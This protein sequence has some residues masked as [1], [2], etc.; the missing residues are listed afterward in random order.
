MVEKLFYRY[1]TIDAEDGLYIHLSIFKAVRETKCFYIVRGYGVN[2]SGFE[3]IHGRERR[4]L[5]SDE[6]CRSI[7]HTKESAMREFKRRQV[8]R[9]R[10]ANR[11]QQIAELS[12]EFL[13]ANNLSSLKDE[14]QLITEG[15]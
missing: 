3:F 4:V 12:L 6:H 8:N 9:I 1:S 2:H 15:V 14:Y 11:S 5:K 7:S 13:K 10:L